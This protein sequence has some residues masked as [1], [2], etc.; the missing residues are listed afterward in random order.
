MTAHKYKGK[1]TKKFGGEGKGASPTSR[2]ERNL[3]GLEVICKKFRI[4]KMELLVIT[5]L[6]RELKETKQ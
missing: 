5:F 4:P 6:W 3:S 2:L 1:N